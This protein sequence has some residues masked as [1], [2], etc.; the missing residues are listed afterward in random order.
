MAT[1]TWRKSH[2][3]ITREALDWN[4]QG[5]RKQGRP[6]QSWK[7]TRLKELKNIG[8]TWNEAKGTAQNRVRW[9]ATVVGLMLHKEGRGLSKQVSVMGDKI[10][11]CYN[12]HIV[13][14]FAA[15]AMGQK[16]RL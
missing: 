11:H 12:V 4:P 10:V 2:N 14:K 9:R 7:R 13:L 15:Q 8:K 6:L 1:H 16:L 3:N 5:Q